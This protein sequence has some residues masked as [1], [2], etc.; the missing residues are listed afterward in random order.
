[1]QQVTSQNNQ[2]E[3]IY[4]PCGKYMIKLLLNGI[5]RKIVIDDLFPCDMYGNMLCSYSNNSSE[6]W[7]SL[8]EKAYMKVHGGYAF[9]GT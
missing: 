8:I 1:M 2:G 5:W 4:N 6:Y 3:P 9:P 7:V